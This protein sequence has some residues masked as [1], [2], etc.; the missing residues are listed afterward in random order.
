[1]LMGARSTFDEI[2]STLEVPKGRIDLVDWRAISP[3]DKDKR[4]A[5]RFFD[6]A[7]VI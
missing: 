7:V 6:Q 5:T 2:A 1:M 4:N 3:V